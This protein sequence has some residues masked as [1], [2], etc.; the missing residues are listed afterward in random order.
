MVSKPVI[1][2]RDIVVPIIALVVIPFGVTVI[3]NLHAHDIRISQNTSEIQSNKRTLSERK[4]DIKEL[5]E[6]VKEILRLLLKK[7]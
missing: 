5:K 6:D 2:F 3:A 7:N 1:I 4:D